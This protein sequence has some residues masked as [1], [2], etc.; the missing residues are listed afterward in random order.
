[1]FIANH[2]RIVHKDYRS[3]RDLFL[4]ADAP[5]IVAVER[6]CS[7][8]EEEEEE[9][10]VSVHDQSGASEQQDNEEMVKTGG[11]PQMTPINLEDIVQPMQQ[12]NPALPTGGPPIVSGPT[13]MHQNGPDCPPHIPSAHNGPS[14][15]YTAAQPTQQQFQQVSGV[16]Y[17]QVLLPTPTSTPQ[18]FATP[19]YVSMMAPPTTM[20]SPQF[21][22]QQQTSPA[23]SGAH[24]HQQL[25]QTLAAP[26]PQQPARSFEPPK[27]KIIQVVVPSRVANQMI[28]SQRYQLVPMMQQMGPGAMGAAT[29]A[30]TMAASDLQ[31]ASQVAMA[32]T[33]QQ[34]QQQQQHPPGTVFVPM[35]PM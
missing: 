14:Q 11:A 5:P 34:Q 25:Y 8:E 16:Q 22:M 19:Q 23:A 15:G 18:Q 31:Y 17:Q 32:P 35:Y 3:W 7:E 6:D 29:A 1:V 21:M 33:Q 2:F 20:Q 24:Q 26:S 27:Y 9:E 30:P 4:R 12:D 28:E 13:W 10:Q